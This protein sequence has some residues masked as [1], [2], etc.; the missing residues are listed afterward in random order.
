MDIR[1]AQAEDATG[2]RKVYAAGNRETY[3]GLLPKHEIERVIE[4]QQNSDS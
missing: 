2:I 3:P 4:R 1:K